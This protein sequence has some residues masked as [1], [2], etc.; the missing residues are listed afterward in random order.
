[1][2]IVL[3]MSLPFI[4]L[5]LKDLLLFFDVVFEVLEFSHKNTSKTLNS[6]H[7]W[8][9]TITPKC[10]L[11]VAWVALNLLYFVCRWIHCHVQWY[12]FIDECLIITKSMVIV[13]I[14]Q[15]S[16]YLLQLSLEIIDYVAILMGV[17]IVKPSPN[18]RTQFFYIWD[19]MNKYHWGKEKHSE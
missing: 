14:S 4:E 8:S 6:M 7:S 17:K 16:L 11:I 1:M 19:L 5:I 12:Y 10:L 18:K 3:Y 9:Q 2:W 13:D 15:V